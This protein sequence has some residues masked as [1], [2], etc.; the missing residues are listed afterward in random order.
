MSFLLYS[1]H[2]SLLNKTF[3]SG[4]SARRH[5]KRFHPQPDVQLE[6]IRIVQDEPLTFMGIPVVKT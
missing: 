1:L 4:H 2:R 5:L 6:P 3:T